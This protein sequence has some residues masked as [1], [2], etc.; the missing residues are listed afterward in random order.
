MKSSFTDLLEG[1]LTYINLPASYPRRVRKNLLRIIVTIVFIV[2]VLPLASSVF[3]QTPEPSPASSPISMQADPAF[4]GY[5]KYGEWL[6]IWV[7]LA[8]EGPDVEAEIRVHVTGGQGGMTFALPVDLA[9]ISRK[10]VSIYILPNNFSRQI[11]VQL[12]AKDSLLAS[13]T[14]TVKPQP[15]IN[16]LVGL[17]ASR[18]NALSLINGVK[19]PGQERP[20]AL[21]DLTIP[22]LPDR[23]EGLRS[24]DLLVINDVDTSKLTP[25]Q[26]EALETWVHQG[27]RLVIGGGA[28]TERTL[29]SLPDTLLPFSPTGSVEL[30]DVSSLEDF[31]RDDSGNPYPIRVPGPFLVATGE[32]H[33]GRF[34]AKQGE[35]PLLIE[36]PTGGG[37]VNFSSLDLSASPFD[38]WSGTTAFWE[39]ILSPGGAYPEWLPPDVSTRQQL[40]S[41]MPYALSNLP[42]LD[43]PSTGGLVALLGLYI[44]LVGPINYL[45]L[46]WQKRLHWAWVTIPTITLIFSGAAFALGYALHGTDVFVNKIAIIKLQPTGRAHV[47]SY[48]GLFSPARSAYEVE[49]H[50]D[51]LLSPLGPHYDPWNSFVPPPGLTSREMVFVQGDPGYV[52]G[53]NVEQW[54]MQSFMA[55]GLSI[56]FGH[57]TSDLRLE[58]DSLV[59]TVL[60]KSSYTLK[61]V[62]I[63]QGKSFTRLNDLPAGAEMRVDINLSDMARPSFGPPI[64]YQLFEQDLAS[65]RQGDPSRQ[66]EVRRIVV[67]NIFERAIAT[68][69]S[70][71]SPSDS[72]SANLS[73]VPMLIGWLD[74]APPDVLIAGEEPAQQTTALLLMPLTYR[75]P[76][77]GRIVL[78]IGSIPGSLTKA[79][80]EGGHCGE[81]G[82]TAIYLNR[83]DAIFEFTLPSDAQDLQA[84]N[85]KLALWSDASPFAA[86]EV[87]LRDWNAETWVS[88]KGLSQ[89]VNLV[90]GASDLINSQGSIQV[91]LSSTDN[92]PGNCFYVALGLVG[93]RD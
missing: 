52:S 33:S 69:K 22:E 88:L 84:E 91:R 61:D 66:A 73:Q 70:F 87:T 25:E 81:P 90:P 47:D 10:R 28:G 60:N 82:A 39:N 93:Y 27:G 4:E 12:F 6:P 83:G 80:R 30:E 26:V 65:S 62:V 85:L 68:P 31:A 77:T 51:G 7:E 42:M 63:V 55:E 15:P 16:Y 32:S 11:E 46:R 71:T 5:F 35:F 56:E 72:Y 57:V 23:Y 79:P 49:I 58:E 19:L 24:F 34:L 48:I 44:I 13:N 14:I 21:V 41:Q 40:A 78:P 89:G 76:E 2:A 86:P 59:G 38:A 17:I 9:T 1:M 74:E 36:W 45:V 37:T 75:L 29:T 3:A 53:L 67:E 64:S 20:M 18:D 50:G 54:S 92:A 8:N 43:L